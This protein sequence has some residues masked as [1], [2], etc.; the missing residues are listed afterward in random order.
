MELNGTGNRD[1]SRIPLAL[2]EECWN[3]VDHGGPSPG[4][5]DGDRTRDLVNAI[6]ARSQLRHSPSPGCLEVA[7]FTAH[8]AG[9]FL[10]WGETPAVDVTM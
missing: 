4:G 6:H 2:L 9:D 10:R 8:R 1:N 3:T 5:A 7:E